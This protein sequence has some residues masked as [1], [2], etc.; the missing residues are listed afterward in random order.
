MFWDYLGNPWLG[1]FIKSNNEITIVPPDATEKLCRLLNERLKTEIVKTLIAESNLIGL[2]SV[3]NSK[4]IVLPNI[5]KEEEVTI[6][7][8]HGL[9]IYLSSEKMNAHGNNITVTDKTGI[10][11]K[12]VSQ[13]EKK[14][15]E[16]ALGVELIETTVAGYNAVGSACIATNKGFLV[17]YKTTETELAQIEKAF[18][19]DGERGTVN[20]GI[21]FIGKGLVANEH[22][23][24]PGSSTTGFELSRIHSALGFL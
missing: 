12:D 24:L 14:A 10:I 1:T 20:M 11:S 19:L 5:V 8:K 13:N 3:M 16:D 18:Q 4:G 22:G 23:Y 7:K 2:Y 6:L 9:N 17:H 21:G 15:I